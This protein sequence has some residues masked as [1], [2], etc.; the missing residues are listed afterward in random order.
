[1]NFKIVATI[2][3]SET[4][5]G[6]VGFANLKQT[7]FSIKFVDQSVVNTCSGNYLEWG[8]GTWYD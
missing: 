3:G 8:Q 2:A 1:M 7:N 5:G 6:T 4:D